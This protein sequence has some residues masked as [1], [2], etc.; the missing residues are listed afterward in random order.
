MTDTADVA[1]FS[2]A[3]ALDFFEQ[4]VERE[5]EI[6]LALNGVK[7]ARKAL[8][9]LRK[10]IKDNGINLESFDLARR[11]ARLT[12]EEREEHDRHYRRLMAFIGKPLGSQGMFEFGDQSEEDKA[13]VL[14]TVLKHADREGHAAGR[15]GD[16]A[17]RNPWHPGSEEFSTWQ[18]AWGRGNG[19]RVTAE[20]QPT[21]RPGR[22]RKNQAAQT[23]GATPPEAVM[24]DSEVHA[25]G[26]ADGLA[27]HRENADK[28]P[29][30]AE[31]HAAYELG[32]ADGVAHADE[33]PE[34]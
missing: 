11:S 10:E 31:G 3:T 22:P 8:K 18:T 27:G 13:A 23:N 15:A 1:Q 28:Y 20:I 33:Q 19:A 6:G 7:A 29:P 17:D 30:G 21:R 32:H 5:S 34:A 24:M 16:K 4:H 26:V 14:A 2:Q 25:L 12:S 9:D